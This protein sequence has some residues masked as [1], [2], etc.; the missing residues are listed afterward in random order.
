MY[1][2]QDGVGSARRRPALIIPDFRTFEEESFVRKD[3][4]NA[5]L[6]KIPVPSRPNK[7]SPVRYYGA[8]E[9]PPTPQ[10]K[11]DFSTPFSM[12]VTPTP[13]TSRHKSY[14]HDHFDILGHL[15]R[16]SF[17]EVLRCRCRD[18]GK[19]YAVKCTT[20]PIHTARDR[21]SALQE[22]RTRANLGF[23]PHLVQYHQ[24]WEEGGQLFIQIELCP[25]TLED[26]L[27]KHVDVEEAALWDFA[28]DIAL[29]LKW[30][31]DRN[32]VHL[33]VKPD[34][35]FIK[36]AGTLKLGDFGLSH[37]TGRNWEATSFRRPGLDA[38]GGHGDP[39]RTADLFTTA[40]PLSPML[41]VN[42]AQRLTIDAALAHPV[43][44]QRLQL[45]GYVNTPKP[46]RLLRKCGRLV[47]TV[48]AKLLTF[49]A[50]PAAQ[51]PFIAD[52]LAATAI[53]NPQPAGEGP[54]GSLMGGGSAFCSLTRALTC[55]GCPPSGGA[56]AGSPFA[57][58]EESMQY[59]RSLMAAFAECRAEEAVAAAARADA[60]R[61]DAQ[62]QLLAAADPEPEHPPASPG[63]S[64]FV[65]S[66]PTPRRPVPPP[67]PAR[68]PPTPTRPAAPRAGTPPATCGGRTPRPA[69]ITPL[70]AAAAALGLAANPII[71]SPA[72]ACASPTDFSPI[73]PQGCPTPH[74]VTAPPLD[75]PRP[76]ADP[77]MGPSPF[78]GPAMG[79]PATTTAAAAASGAVGCLLSVPPSPSD[80]L[81]AVETPTAELMSTPLLSAQSFPPSDSPVTPGAASASAAYGWGSGGGG[82]GGGGHGGG[83]PSPI[84]LAPPPT[85]GHPRAVAPAPLSIPPPGSSP[86][87]PAASPI[88]PATGGS[89][90]YFLPPAM[91]SPPV[92]P[93]QSAMPPAGLAGAGSLSEFRFAS[94]PA[95]AAAAAQ[96]RGSIPP[97]SLLSGG[98]ASTEPP[99]AAVLMHH[100]PGPQLPPPPSATFS[101]PGEA[102]AAPMER[103]DGEGRQRADEEEDDEGAIHG[104]VDTPPLGSRPAGATRREPSSLRTSWDGFGPE[105]SAPVVPPPVFMRPPPTCPALLRRRGA[106]A[107]G[108]DEDLDED[109]DEPTFSLNDETADDWLAGRAP[110]LAP[111]PAPAAPATT[112]PATAGPNS[113][114][115]LATAAQGA[116]PQLQARKK[117]RT[118]VAADSAPPVLRHRPLTGPLLGVVVAGPA[119][120]AAGPAGDEFGDAEAEAAEAAAEGDGDEGGAMALE[121]DE[122]DEGDAPAAG[123]P[124][125]GAEAMLVVPRAPEP[126]LRRGAA[127]GASGSEGEAWQLLVCDLYALISAPPLM[128][129]MPHRMSRLAQWVRTARQL[130]PVEAANPVPVP[131]QMAVLGTVMLRSFDDPAV[132]ASSYEYDPENP[133]PHLAM[134]DDTAGFLPAGGPASARLAGR[135]LLVDPSRDRLH[136]HPATRRR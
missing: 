91:P 63:P 36:G 75:S 45:R 47:P 107:G 25:G 31:H 15:G 97:D 40:R 114:G 14:F 73:A 42:P 132:L 46:I 87:L 58:T 93:Q 7:Q 127:L 43:L 117:H 64:P 79:P 126:P 118:H 96:P 108:P 72:D 48:S 69:P 23:H 1:E 16:G 17:A 74:A 27:Y 41:D 101:S 123:Q 119:D 21:D 102:G 8:R 2:E 124:E 62:P 136:P 106:G 53:G 22:L 94:H 12:K 26:Y 125:G 28:L 65:L 113:G 116:A 134:P 24:A 5:K 104:S 98:S 110:A 37:H 128:S 19:E 57:A 32:I 39:P 109:L 130:P 112:T 133:P 18:D 111:A 85:P 11:I 68:Q 135:P 131:R 6:K 44:A 81:A 103:A 86:L 61:L 30:I 88:I 56:L 49:A 121:E 77:A 89:A 20:K 34:N 76:E 100:P 54:V 105:G 71:R 59:H 66:H 67:S 52:P 10:Y 80:R 78:L 3:D 55:R 95:T 60:G 90:A 38:G 115:R 29:G 4:P 92:L 33:D 13:V 82:G 50:S 129:I 9:N 35:I 83:T 99:R 120:D 84:S 70:V 51:L 122:P